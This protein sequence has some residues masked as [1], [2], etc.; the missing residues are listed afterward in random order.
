MKRIIIIAA[1]LFM[2]TSGAM[3]QEK[4]IKVDF[5]YRKILNPELLWIDTNQDGK[6]DAGEVFSAGNGTV[7]S[8]GID[9]KDFGSAGNITTV[10]VT[11]KNSKGTVVSKANLSDGRFLIKTGTNERNYIYND[12]LGDIV[13]GVTIYDDGSKPG[14]MLIFNPAAFELVMNK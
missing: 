8:V 1:C 6:A 2:A 7:L 9:H 5:D 11:A 14:S 12:P 4:T 10:E 13:F 3:A